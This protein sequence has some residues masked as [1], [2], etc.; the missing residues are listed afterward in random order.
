MSAV[1]C[2]NENQEYNFILMMNG[3]NPFTVSQIPMTQ[4]T[5]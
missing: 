1:I 2:L 3:N 5:T 4:S